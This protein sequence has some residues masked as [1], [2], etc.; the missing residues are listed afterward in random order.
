MVRLCRPAGPLSAQICSDLGFP[1]LLLVSRCVN[2]DTAHPTAPC[3]PL[4][5][6]VD[7]SY[8]T[9]SPDVAVS[10]ENM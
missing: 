2:Q 9:P 8:P 5:P 7:F 4:F 3:G 10:G 1:H 6:C